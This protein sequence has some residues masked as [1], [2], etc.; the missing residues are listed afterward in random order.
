MPGLT[1]RVLSQSI[2]ELDPSPQ[3]RAPVDRVVELLV[4]SLGEELSIDEINS[5]IRSFSRNNSDE[6]I[7]IELIEFLRGKLPE[8]RLEFTN[9][10]FASISK[11]Q[12]SIVTESEL[13][14]SFNSAAVSRLF[15]GQDLPDETVGYLLDSFYVY[16]PLG[17][18]QGYSKVDFLEYYR[19]VSAEV[20][21]EDLFE[22]IVTKS[23]GVHW[24]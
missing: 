13:I 5:L 18:Q 3:G 17:V 15:G 9:Q 1:I 24:K 23:W 12:S 20:V 14:S 2:H 7:L 19:D 4:D 11:S 10:A 8:W 21:D 16:N 6:I 22:K